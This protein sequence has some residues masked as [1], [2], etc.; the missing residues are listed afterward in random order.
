MHVPLSRS[1]PEHA[2]SNSLDRH[3]GCRHGGASPGGQQHRRYDAGDTL[4]ASARAPPMPD[5]LIRPRRLRLFL[6]R[7]RLEQRHCCLPRRG[8]SAGPSS[9]RRD[10]MQSVRR[11]SHSS[12]DASSRCRESLRTAALEPARD[13]ATSSA[14]TSPVDGSASV[15]ELKCPQAGQLEGNC[16]ALLTKVSVHARHSRIPR[17]LVARETAYRAAPFEPSA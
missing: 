11:R 17:W 2:V 4:T 6:R 7:V 3:S 10:R 1:A 13:A 15:T 9:C 12:T 14:I 8:P 5:Q 16:D